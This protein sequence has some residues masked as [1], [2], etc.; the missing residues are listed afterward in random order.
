MFACCLK[1]APRPWYQRFATYINHLRFVVFTSDTSLFVWRQHASLL[2]Y[3]DNI[4][5]TASS[6]TLLDRIIERLHFEFAMTKLDDLHQFLASLSH[7]SSS[8]FLSQCQYIVD[9]VEGD[10]MTEYHPTATPVDA[11]AKLSATN[12]ALV[13]ETTK[14]GY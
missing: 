4:I 12:S 1:Q 3:I 6:P 5:I 9:L 11:R 2:L 13:A 8:L 10:S 7:C 14:H